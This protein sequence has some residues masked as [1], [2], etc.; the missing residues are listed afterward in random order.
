[1][2]EFARDLCVNER[3]DEHPCQE[4]AYS[5]KVRAP[6]C[7][8]PERLTGRCQ[9]AGRSYASEPDDIGTAPWYLG[10]RS[11]RC[12]IDGYAGSKR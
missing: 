5:R 7:A 10:R 8:L 6:Y 4:D 1:M 3:A 12:V 9:R 11:I 2:T